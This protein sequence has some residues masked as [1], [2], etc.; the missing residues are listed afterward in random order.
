M[1][2]IV[3]KYYI[4]KDSFK[5]PEFYVMLAIFQSDMTNLWVVFPSKFKQ[6]KSYIDSLLPTPLGLHIEKNT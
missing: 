4:Y 3:K 6:F 2:E 1:S 5:E